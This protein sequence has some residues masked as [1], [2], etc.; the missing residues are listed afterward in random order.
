MLTKTLSFLNSLKQNNNRDWFHANKTIYNEA[1][2]EFEALTEILI[3]ETSK[4]DPD[5]RGLHPKD[6]IFRIF[7]D[8]RF[9]TDKTPYKTNFGTYLVRNGRKSGYAGYYL[10]IDPASSFIAGGIYMPPSNILRSV[11]TEIYEHVEEFKSIISEAESKMDFNELHGD[12]LKT[13]PKG[14]PKDFPDIDLLKY[15]SYGLSREITDKQIKDDT[16]IGEVTESFR[17]LTPLIH[18]LNNGVENAL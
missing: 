12:K 18:F 1:K 7:R 14:F 3:Y 16:L 6:C 15:K 13:A 9:S 10:H 11:R 8:I 2:E 17:S 4:F 5:I